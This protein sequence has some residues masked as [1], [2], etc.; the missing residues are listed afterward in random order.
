MPA[1]VPL[2]LSS[3]ERETHDGFSK[4]TLGQE[5]G[6]KKRT[7]ILLWST[8]ASQWHSIGAGVEV[9]VLCLLLFIC[10]FLSLSLPEHLLCAWRFPTRESC[11]QLRC[12]GGKY[13][14]FFPILYKRHLL[15]KSRVRAENKIKNNT[16]T[17]SSS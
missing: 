10:S 1:D 5:F 9:G 17:F 13:P 14:V 15:L 4:Q 16:L 8:L 12:F 3:I 11:S 6:W 7:P 2:L